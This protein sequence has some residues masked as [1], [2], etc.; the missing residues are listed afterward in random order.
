MRGGD[1]AQQI[2]VEEEAAV[3]GV[4]EQDPAEGEEEEGVSS[5]LAAV[6]S[7]KALVG[8]WEA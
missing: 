2:C 4:L 8:N 6:G 5:G 7:G 3:V 1:A